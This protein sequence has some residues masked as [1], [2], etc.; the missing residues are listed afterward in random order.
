MDGL[1]RTETDAVSPDRRL[2]TDERERRILNT[3]ATAARRGQ[4]LQLHSLTLRK[5]I[6]FIFSKKED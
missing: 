5:H 2:S 4:G 6:L 3:F 1:Y